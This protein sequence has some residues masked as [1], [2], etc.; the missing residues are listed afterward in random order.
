MDEGETKKQRDLIQKWTAKGMT[1]N[2]IAELLD[3]SV[4]Q[5][6]KLANGHAR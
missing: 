4:A 5:V 2:Q 3:V 1:E 6:R